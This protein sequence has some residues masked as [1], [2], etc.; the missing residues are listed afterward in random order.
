[1]KTQSRIDFLVESLNLL[2]H[3]EGGF[4]KET[5]R[6]TETIPTESGNRNLSTS[7]FFLLTSA[8]VSKFHRIKSDEL[9]F[10]HE[11]SALTIHLL[12]DTG[13]QELRLGL[14][15][16]NEKQLPYQVVKANTIFGSTVDSQDSYALVSCVVSPGFDFND[17]QLFEKEALVSKYP[18]AYDIISRLT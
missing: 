3:P 4:Y 16:E 14:P 2:P 7:I 17:F 8:N 6:S 11:G 10:F 5:Y 12:N 1:M 13:H 15:Y 9:W 18:E